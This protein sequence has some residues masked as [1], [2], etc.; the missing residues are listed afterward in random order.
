MSYKA[1]VNNNVAKAFNLLK[2]L[3]DDVE[4]T[5]KDTAAFDFGTASVDTPTQTVTTVKAVVTEL[6]DIHKDQKDKRKLMMLKTQEVGDLSPYAHVDVGGGEIW[7]FG[8]I[9]VSDRFVTLVEIYR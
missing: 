2:D 5:K 9:V 8:P 6:K 1:L 4:L 3:A 7:K